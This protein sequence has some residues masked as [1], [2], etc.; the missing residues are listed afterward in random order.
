M[1]SFQDTSTGFKN[2]DGAGV[3]T[4]RIDDND[5][6][7]VFTI[8]NIVLRLTCDRQGQIELE[9]DKDEEYDDLLRS[10]V[11]TPTWG[12][13]DFSI[14]DGDCDTVLGD[15]TG[16]QVVGEECDSNSDCCTDLE[17]RGGVCQYEDD[18]CDTDG[19]IDVYFFC[20]ETECRGLQFVD[21]EITT[22]HPCAY[23][24]SLE[25]NTPGGDSYDV[26][27]FEEFDCSQ[28]GHTEG[29]NYVTAKFTSNYNHNTIKRD[30]RF[31][32]DD[33]RV[34]PTTPDWRLVY[35]M[36]DRGFHG[37]DYTGEW[38]LTLDDMYE[39]ITG[40]ILEASVKLTCGNGVFKDTIL[41]DS[42]GSSAPSDN[43]GR[44]VCDWCDDY[45][46]TFECQTSDAS[47]NCNAQG[48]H[49]T[50]LYPYADPFMV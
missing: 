21:V 9:F 27:N 15:C 20:A 45:Q 5:G 41:G 30:F 26:F 46:V 39:E 29:S 7:G 22:T 36:D 47:P 34:I 13:F 3:W 48:F 18:D 38:S 16:F 43:S 4:L 23:Q 44:G 28:L 10:F 12:P 33:D 2:G 31:Y 35:E 11:R 24:L 6:A 49:W 37:E 8:N 19:D 14:P 42:S 50:Q 32:D 17:C 40:E 25:L 1:E